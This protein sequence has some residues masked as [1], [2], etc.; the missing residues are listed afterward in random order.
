MRNRRVTGPFA[1]NTRA[2]VCGIGNP[3]SQD[4]MVCLCD[5]F[6]ELLKKIESRESCIDDV[7]EHTRKVNVLQ[8]QRSRIRQNSNLVKN[9]TRAR[10]HSI[11]GA[12]SVRQ[13]QRRLSPIEYIERFQEG[14]GLPAT[15]TL[16]GLC[17]R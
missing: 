7:K 2:L 5:S 9:V 15:E 3:V 13:E 12:T 6:R 4:V 17:G 8:Q 11:G 1:D 14:E 10:F 16:T